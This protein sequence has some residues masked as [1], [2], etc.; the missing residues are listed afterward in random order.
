MDIEYRMSFNKDA[1]D[2]DLVDSFEEAK[3]LVPIDPQGVVGGFNIRDVKILRGG[4]WKIEGDQSVFYYKIKI[5]NK[6]KFVINN[7]QILLTLIPAGLQVESDRYRINLLKPNSFESPT[8]KLNATQ[9]CVGDSVEGIITYIDP[10]GTMQ[11][12]PIEPFEI[13]YVCNLLTPKQIS[14]KEFDE[15][16]QFMEDRKL[17]ID[18]DVDFSILEKKIVQIIK[19]CNFEM[20]QEMKASQSVNFKIFEAYAQGLYDKQDVA[21]SIAL[22]KVGDG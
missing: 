1:N 18:S 17:I 22:K 5:K 2:F 9:S 4:D 13:C 15:K 8:F 6:S 16:T 12:S 21:L 7:I 14:K 10:S 3:N 20:L 19:N 11:T